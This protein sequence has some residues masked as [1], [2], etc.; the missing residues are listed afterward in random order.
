MDIERDR[1]WDEDYELDDDEF[2]DAE[3]DELDAEAPLLDP[4][5]HPF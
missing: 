2:E 3:T 4:L 1:T 5:E